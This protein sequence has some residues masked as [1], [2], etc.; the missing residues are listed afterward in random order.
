MNNSLLLTIGAL[1]DQIR[2]HSNR[3]SI[4]FEPFFLLK[5]KTFAIYSIIFFFQL[6]QV[7]NN[8]ALR[9]NT[10]PLQPFNYFLFKASLPLFDSLS[11]I[12]S[13]QL[14]LWT[15]QPTTPNTQVQSL[16][17]PHKDPTSPR[18]KRLLSELL[19]SH[20]DR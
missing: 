1:Q 3:R 19:I 14:Y 13:T 4:H 5:I 17:T 10:S 12:N 6:L 9:A 11:H 20:N 16:C 18:S 7:K 15:T 8:S 2:F